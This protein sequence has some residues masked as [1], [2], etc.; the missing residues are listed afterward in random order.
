MLFDISLF[1]FIDYYIQE[2]PNNLRVYLNVYMEA[3]VRWSVSILNAESLVLFAP[4]AFR[5]N[6]SVHYSIR[7]AKKWYGANWKT[8]STKIPILKSH[9]SAGCKI[10]WKFSF[11]I[12]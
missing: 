7:A 6:R 1:Y 10:R 2:C 11:S 8:L 12:C 3:R 4:M 5:R 9:S